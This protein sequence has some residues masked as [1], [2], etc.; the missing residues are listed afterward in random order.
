MVFSSARPGPARWWAGESWPALAPAPERVDVAADTGERSADGLAVPAAGPA[1]V[2][3]A[4]D[5]A[6]RS[7]ESAQSVTPTEAGEAAGARASGRG[8][9]RA[10]WD[11]SIPAGSRGTDLAELSPTQCCPIRAEVSATNRSA[12]RGNRYVIDEHRLPAQRCGRQGGRCRRGGR[13]WCCWSSTRFRRW[14]GWA[15]RRD[16]RGPDHR[17]VTRCYG[18]SVNRRP[19][20]VRPA[21]W[22][23]PRDTDTKHTTRRKTCASVQTRELPAPGEQTPPPRAIGRGFR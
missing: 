19:Q 1:A 11:D 23:R 5:V 15:L 14:P 7:E 22:P 21:R 9:D 16:S 20:G 8:W 17:A 18:R 2:A 3:A 10:A 12:L 4:E 6:V 13:C